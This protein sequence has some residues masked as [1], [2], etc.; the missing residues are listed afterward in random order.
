MI[1]R[2]LV[3]DD[4]FMVREFVEE[5]I[6]RLGF[7]VL[8][9]ANGEEAVEALR[10]AD[11]HMA[12]VDLK[13]GRLS[14]MDVL[15]F[16]NQAAPRVVFVIMTA[17][18]DV[19]LAAEAIE[20]GA[21][22]FLIKPFSPEQTAIVIEKARRRQAPAEPAPAPAALPPVAPPPPRLLGGSRAIRSVLEMASRVAPT[23]ATVLITGESGTGKELVAREI[24][25][26]SD[27]DGSRPFIRMNCAAVPENLLESE[28][29]GHEKGAFTGAVGRRIGRFERAHG[30]TLLLDE[31]GEISPAMQAKLLR[32][33]QEQEF[34]RVGGADTIQVR[35]RVIATTNRDLKAEVDRRRFREDLFYRLNVFPIHVPPLRDREDDV[36]TLAAAFLDRQARSLGR[37]LR[38]R[39]E[40]LES[41]CRY[42][43]PGN[44]REMENVIERIAILA[45]GPD[46]L[47]GALPAEVVHAA[48]SPPPAI[49]DPT[50][51]MRELECRTIARALRETNGNRTRAAKL[52]G[53]SVR[54]LRNK[55]HEADIAQAVAAPPHCG[56]PI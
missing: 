31:I 46:I 32:V 13:M 37:P 9:A 4:E 6:R 10:T 45:D 54:T 19:D 24:H 3:V 20:L 15:R 39:P 33:L 41:L 7:T 43:W 11:V 34:E 35:V 5:S 21:F 12:F 51:N 53:Y 18:G 30:G 17:Y 27:P 28:L 2:I 44:V 14:G 1:E 52:L 49:G 50:F 40:A 16:R 8:S 55:L 26:R 22:D 23:Q 42:P 36:A 47:A 38:F 48:A 56:V 25:A 29:F